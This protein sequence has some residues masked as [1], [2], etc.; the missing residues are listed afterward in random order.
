MQSFPSSFT[1]RWDSKP[2]Q[3]T[4]ARIASPRRSSLD[5][6]TSLNLSKLKIHE[7]WCD[8]EQDQKRCT[9]SIL[10]I[11]LA[12]VGSSCMRLDSASKVTTFLLKLRVRKFHSETATSLLLPLGMI[13]EKTTPP[14][15]FRPT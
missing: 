7:I 8:Q 5:Q 9:C 14:R 11:C 1:R 4:I 3:R 15:S 13:P 10:L 2:R 12:N 6:G